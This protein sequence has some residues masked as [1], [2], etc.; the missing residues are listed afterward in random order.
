MT[1]FGSGEKNGFRV[2]IRSLNHR[3][4]EISLKVHPF[5]NK[6][7]IPLR[8]IIKERFYRGKFDVS[9]SISNK[10]SASLKINKESAKS[11]YAALQDLQKDLSLP[12]E[13]N[14][15]TIT[16]Y[17]TLFIIEEEPE[18][19]VDALYV[20]FREAISEL[21]AM[22][23]KEGKFIMDEL[24]NRIELLTHIN[25]EIKLLAHRETENFRERLTEKLKLI[26]GAEEI[27]TNRIIQ[28]VAIM[29]EKMD[30]SEEINRIENHIKQFI[31]IFNNGNIIGRKLDFLLQEINREVNTLSC[32][33]CDYDISRLVVEMKTEIEKIREQVQNI[34]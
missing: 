21:E 22:R 29:A 14:I 24:H 17:G 16:E 3:F 8:N 2:E 10:E 34:Q 26:L 13:I 6:Y 19:N 18:Y 31:E 12:G 5:M 7:D 23:I 1:G 28:E 32:K 30:I 15:N 33:A 9:V 27:D 25:N 20:A 11:V 4:I